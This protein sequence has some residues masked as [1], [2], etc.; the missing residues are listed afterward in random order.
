[1]KACHAYWFQLLIKTN[2]NFKKT[3]LCCHEE[4]S[5]INVVNSSADY[6]QSNTW[7]DV[8]I[9]AL[10]WMESPAFVSHG[11][12]GRAWCKHTSTF[13]MCVTVLCSTF[14]LELDSLV[15]VMCKKRV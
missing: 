6:S 13:S 8:C 12:E 1:M 5:I 11:V 2:F 10:A 14:S 9:I 4:N 3:N 7:E 15:K